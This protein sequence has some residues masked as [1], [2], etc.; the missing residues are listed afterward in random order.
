M[1]ASPELEPALD[2]EADR[3]ERLESLAEVAMICRPRLFA[4][5]GMYRN[6]NRGDILGWG[7]EFEYDDWTVFVEP[8]DGGIHYSDTADRVRR[9]LS[10]IADIRLTWL[11]G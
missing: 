5:H 11:D 3:R 2:S 1:A 8:P 7:L 6:P 4:I 10:R 9:S